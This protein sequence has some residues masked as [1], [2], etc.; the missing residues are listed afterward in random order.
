MQVLILEDDQLLAQVFAEALE[1]VGHSVTLAHT[2]DVATQHLRETQFDLLIF[3]L[4]IDGETCIPVLDFANYAAPDAE[5]ILVTGSGL[6]PRGE[7]HYSIADVSYRIQ[8]PVKLSDLVLVVEHFER[9]RMA[10]RA[11]VA[12]PNET[13]LSA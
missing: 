9:T 1:E 8:K 11:S 5:V 4:L 3:D 6:F 7:M 12:D 13:T 2:N 10:R